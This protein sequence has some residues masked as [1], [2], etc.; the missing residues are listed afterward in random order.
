MLSLNQPPLPYQTTVLPM[1]ICL[2]AYASLTIQNFIYL[3]IINSRKIDGL[4]E[5][6]LIIQMSVISHASLTGQ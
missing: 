1:R 6:G 2:M 4:T 5:V 3:F